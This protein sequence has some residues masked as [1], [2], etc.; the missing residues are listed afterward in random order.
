MGVGD[1]RGFQ[2]ARVKHHLSGIPPSSHVSLSTIRSAPRREPGYRLGQSLG[3]GKWWNPVELRA[4]F[5]VI[6]G[7]AVKQASDR[8]RFSR[9]VT[10]QTQEYIRHRKQPRRPA[11]GGADA[12]HWL[13]MYNGESIVVDRK[14]GN[15]PTIYVPEALVSVT[16]GI[17]PA[18]LHRALGIEHRPLSLEP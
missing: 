5:S 2:S 17:Q 9:E 15:P 6:D 14:T 18:I 3:H 13:S 7:E 12:A 16:G 4:D 11:K 10:G 1:I 8:I